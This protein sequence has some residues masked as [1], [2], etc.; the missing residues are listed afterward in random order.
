MHDLERNRPLKA[1]PD[2]SC[3]RLSTC[4]GLAPGKTCLKTHFASHDDWCDYMAAKINRITQRHGVAAEDEDPLSEDEA[5]AEMYKIFRERE[6]EL[7][8]MEAGKKPKK[9]REPA[10]APQD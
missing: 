5:L 9:R 3:R 2:L 10:L 7:D 4:H 6:R 1:C 8:A